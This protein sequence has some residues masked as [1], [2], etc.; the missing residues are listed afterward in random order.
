MNRINKRCKQFALVAIILIILSAAL[1]VS[2]GL[3]EWSRLG[4]LLPQSGVDP[5]VSAIASHPAQLGT[6]Y[7]GTLQTT[8]SSSLVFKSSNGGESWIPASTGL[9]AGMPQNTG[10]NDL[11]VRAGAPNQLYAGLYQ[12]GLW[13]SSSGGQNWSNV[14]NG[15]I[16]ANDNVRALALDPA[17]S[18]T[19]YALTGSGV[20][21]SING[22]P[23]Q[24]RSSGLP[25]AASTIFNDVAVDALNPGTLYT[26]TNPQGFFRSTNS[27]QSWQPANNGLPAGTLDIKAIAASPVNGRLLI[28]IA[29]QGL[30]R[31]DDRGSTW[32]RSDSGITYNTTL[33]GSVGTPVFS[34]GDAQV[35]YVYNNDG[36]F[37]SGDGGKTWTPVN[38]GFS[39]AETISTMAFHAG[40]PSTVYTGTVVS[41]IL[42]R[43]AVP[44][45]RLYL[46]LVIR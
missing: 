37:T 21:V 17:Q 3:F 41:G 15:S 39:G 16:A 28:S 5:T 25:A 43:T 14:A 19:I 6:L 20:Q 23:F 30:W 35:A 7:A 32:V 4:R 46:P 38:E 40:A 22:A 33:Q 18:S 12:A 13:Y 44:G 31:S 27:G 42:S 8:G 24:K 34:P 11:V 10:V 2:A 45:G 36:A 9:P 29:G 1:P 26:A